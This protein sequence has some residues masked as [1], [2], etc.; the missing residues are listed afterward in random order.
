VGYVHLIIAEM[1]NYIG[2]F[3]ESNRAANA[4]RSRPLSDEAWTAAFEAKWSSGAFLD[5]RE[6]EASMSAE[7]AKRMDQPAIRFVA[8]LGLLLREAY[9]GKPAKVDIDWLI[10]EAD[11]SGVRTRCVGARGVAALVYHARGRASEALTAAREALAIA[12]AGPNRHGTNS[13]REIFALVSGAAADGQDT[14][15]LAE[16]AAR[17]SELGQEY[18]L[19]L[20]YAIIGL[21]TMAE[22]QG[23]ARDVVVLTGYLAGHL[24][25]LG[26][27]TSGAEQLAGGALDRLVTQETAAEFARGK[28][29]STEALYEELERLAGRAPR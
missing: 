6:D 13:A 22:R 8:S 1:A 24:V 11:R 2:A 20:G 12:E 17:A 3:E 14:G 16:T 28:A 19:G 21:V 4:A 10:E 26:L 5:R 29:M 9:G 7:L 18:P 25:E 27:T 23:R 15:D